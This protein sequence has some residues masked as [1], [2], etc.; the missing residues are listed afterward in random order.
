MSIEALTKALDRV[1]LIDCP[2]CGGEGGHY[3]P[4]QRFSRWHLDPPGEIFIPCEECHG[5]GMVEGVA[6][7]LDL[8][9]LAERCGDAA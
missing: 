5:A 7:S 1:E 6:A 3:E 2:A 8:F 9:D 4:E